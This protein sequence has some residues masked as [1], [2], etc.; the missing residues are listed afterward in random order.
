VRPPAPVLAKSLPI[1]YERKF[2]FIPLVVRALDAA[3]ILW[4]IPYLVDDWRDGATFVN[5]G[6]A[7]QANMAHIKKP[8]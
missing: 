6:L 3:G 4:E 8:G 2:I 1:A 7:V 5:V